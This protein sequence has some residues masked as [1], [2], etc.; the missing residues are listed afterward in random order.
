MFDEQSDSRGGKSARRSGPVALADSAA[1]WLQQ[2]PQHVRPL[3]TA[4]QFAHVVNTLAGVW[5]TPQKCRD[6]LDQ[7]LLD[8]RGSRRGFPKAVASELATLKDYYDS[9]VHPTQ[10]TVWDEIVSHARR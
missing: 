7:L 2:L 4:A 8:L 5:N 6:Y 9:I 1:Q 10:Q 3:Q